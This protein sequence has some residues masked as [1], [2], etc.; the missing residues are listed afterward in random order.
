M[1][2]GRDEWSVTEKTKENGRCERDS[3]RWLCTAPSRPPEHTTSTGFAIRLPLHCICSCCYGWRYSSSLPYSAVYRRADA[4]LPR[5]EDRGTCS[6]KHALRG[7]SSL[8]ALSALLLNR[9]TWYLHL[10][11]AGHHTPPRGPA[12]GAMGP[13]R[14]E[15]LN[16]VTESYGTY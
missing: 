16:D 13:R 5:T 4:M 12:I 10:P 11:R 14:V 9:G 8:C 6:Y 1:L 7:T 15:Y 2:E 3:R